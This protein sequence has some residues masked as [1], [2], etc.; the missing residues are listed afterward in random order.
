MSGNDQGLFF[1]WGVKWA[2]AENNQIENSKQYGISIGHHDTDNIV[3]DND[4]RASGQV[5][6]LF[7]NERTAAFQG[8]RNRIENNRIDGVLEDQGVGIDVQGQTQS[9]AIVGN[10]LRETTRR[11]SASGFGLGLKRRKSGSRQTGSRDSPE[12]CSTCVYKRACTK[13]DSRAQ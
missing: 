13:A 1:C 6:I 5:G 3:R 12:T 2:L 11:S 9:I 10:Q 4:I 8:H 7:R